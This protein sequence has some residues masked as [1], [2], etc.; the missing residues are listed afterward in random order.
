MKRPI[1][2]H[3]DLVRKPHGAFGWLDA[4]LLH[5]HHL[6]TLGPPATAVLLL[7]ALAANRHG[8]SYYGRDRM[9]YEL[10]MPRDD[11]DRALV[12][13]LQR[14]LVAF[15]PWRSGCPDGVWQLLP[16]PKPDGDIRSCEPASIHS[17]LARLGLTEV[18]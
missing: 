14:G 1:P 2:P 16:L 7:L 15:R 13:L 4:Y 8:A 6:R 11:L 12:H 17:V 18:P 9:A 5:E 3:P 10:D